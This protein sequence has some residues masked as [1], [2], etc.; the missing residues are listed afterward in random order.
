MPDSRNAMIFHRSSARQ[1]SPATKVSSPDFGSKNMLRLK[2]FLAIFV[3]V[4]VSQCLISTRAARRPDDK[5]F[6]V[7]MAGVMGYRQFD[8]RTGQMGSNIHDIAKGRY[9]IV[10][11][12]ATLRRETFFWLLNDSDGEYEL[13]FPIGRADRVYLLTEDGTDLSVDESHFRID[14]YQRYSSRLR[15]VYSTELSCIPLKSSGNINCLNDFLNKLE[16]MSETT[17]E[18]RSV[19]YCLALKASTSS[20]IRRDLTAVRDYAEY[21]YNPMNDVLFSA[22]ISDHKPNETRMQAE[23]SWYCVDQDPIT[24]QPLGADV[25]YKKYGLPL[26]ADE[27]QAVLRGQKSRGT[28]NCLR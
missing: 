8:H 20:S 28:A 10:K 16:F 24:L 26:S 15:H 13:L 14:C 2:R 27:V 11:Q 6:V 25:F 4:F 23:S 21:G 7:R 22:L 3:V 5:D 1:T 17:A 19:D 9:E 18:H 12:L